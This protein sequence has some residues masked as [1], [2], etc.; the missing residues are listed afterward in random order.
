MRAVVQR[1]STANVTIAEKIF[2]SIGIVIFL[3]IAKGDTLGD[4]EW[5]SK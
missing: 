4:V 3:G 2:S 1:V 5:L